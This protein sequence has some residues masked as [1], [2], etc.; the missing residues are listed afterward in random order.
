MKLLTAEEAAELLRVAPRSIGATAFR[1]RHGIATVRIGRKLLFDR[2]ELER[3][4]AANRE[5][6]AE[7]EPA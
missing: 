6:A 1:R 3:F 5:S 7:R 4:V 2:A